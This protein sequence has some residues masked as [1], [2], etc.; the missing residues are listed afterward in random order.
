MQPASKKNGRQF[1]QTVQ[2]EEERLGLAVLLIRRE[3]LKPVSN[4]D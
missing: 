3:R 2:Q 4:A 1:T